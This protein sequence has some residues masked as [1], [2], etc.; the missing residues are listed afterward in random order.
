MKRHDDLV[1]CSDLF[2]RFFSGIFAY[3]NHLVPRKRREVL[4][5][6][7][8][9]LHRMEYRGY[10]SAGVAVDAGHDPAIAHNDIAIVKLPGKV[11][12]LEAAVMANPKLFD[13]F[14]FDVH[15]GIGHTRWATHGAPSAV[16]SH[17]HRSD[18][19]NGT[20]DTTKV[21]TIR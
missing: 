5:F 2:R 4:E 10:D 16:N 6:I 18:V 20:T 3:I 7:L 8:N 1:F 11:K 14:I 15:V 17:P 19:T 13:D 21:K 9:G 12:V